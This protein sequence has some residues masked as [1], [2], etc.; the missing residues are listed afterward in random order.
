MRPLMIAALFL[1]SACSTDG[2]KLASQDGP[3]C[4]SYGFKPGTDA[5]ANCMMQQDAERER[6]ASEAI[7]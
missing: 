3:R 7:R 2:L 6:R 5:Y 4:Q 1:L